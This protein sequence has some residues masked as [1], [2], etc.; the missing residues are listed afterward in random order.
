MTYLFKSLARALVALSD[1]VMLR[2]WGLRGVD[3]EEVLR[4]RP[5][6]APAW[7]YFQAA[8]LGSLFALMIGYFRAVYV[9]QGGTPWFYT[10]LALM[11][12]LTS[13][14]GFTVY[15]GTVFMSSVLGV[16]LFLIFG[17]YG[18][19]ASWVFFVLVAFSLLIKRPIPQT[20]SKEPWIVDVEAER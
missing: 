4:R 20:D 13:A 6:G 9:E 10:C 18:V 19:L 16:I 2:L 17:A 7:N 15:P 12:S 5:R 1:K 11:W 14:L 8:A 3:D